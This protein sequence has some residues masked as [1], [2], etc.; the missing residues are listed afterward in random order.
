[1]QSIEALRGLPPLDNEDCRADGKKRVGQ[2]VR[3]LV[4]KVSGTITRRSATVA[5]RNTLRLWTTGLLPHSGLLC[6]GRIAARSG[7]SASV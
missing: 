6:A 3:R 5:M 4:Q 7:C 1:M 2:F